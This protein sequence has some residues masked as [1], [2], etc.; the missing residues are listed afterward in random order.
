VKVVLS[1][2]AL[3]VNLAFVV[4]I[5]YLLLR[6]QEGS[7]MDTPSTGDSTVTRTHGKSV[8]DVS[9]SLQDLEGE[10]EVVRAWDSPEESPVEQKQ[11]SHPLPEINKHPR[12]LVN[13]DD[14]TTYTAVMPS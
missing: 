2:L 11:A 13:K 6:R 9:H 8:C 10:R 14:R 12:E 4:Y 3:L 5:V 7:V 1:V